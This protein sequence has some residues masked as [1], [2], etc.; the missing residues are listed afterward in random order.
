MLIVEDVNLNQQF[1]YKGQ[2]T[3]KINSEIDSDYE[4]KL[5]KSPL[6]MMVHPTMFNPLICFDSVDVESLPRKFP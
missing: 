5:F 4:R 2:I 6:M 3:M 1:K